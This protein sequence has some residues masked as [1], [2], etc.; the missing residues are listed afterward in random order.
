MLH[1][2]ND[3]LPIEQF[4]S[5][6]LIYV[7]V[8]FNIDFIYVNYWDGQLITIIAFCLFGLKGLKSG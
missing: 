8:K 7:K 6:H 5:E 2:S 1:T 3:A 4:T